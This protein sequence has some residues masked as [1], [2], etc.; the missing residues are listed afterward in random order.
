MFLYVLI[1][2]DN[3]IGSLKYTESIDRLMLED[4]ILKE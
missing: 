1:E 2:K 3:D 4:E